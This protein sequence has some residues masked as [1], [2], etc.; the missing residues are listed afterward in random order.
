M[1][2]AVIKILQIN[3]NYTFSDTNNIK[4]LKKINIQLLLGLGSFD[5]HKV[6]KICILSE[7]RNVLI[8]NWLFFLISVSMW[9]FFYVVEYCF[10]LY[11]I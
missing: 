4:V 1:T 10:Y 9:K 3:N 8:V 5:L 6:N 11:I 2:R 7:A